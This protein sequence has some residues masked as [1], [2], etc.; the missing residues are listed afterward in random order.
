MSQPGISDIGAIQEGQ[1]VA[2]N[3]LELMTVGKILINLTEEIAMEPAKD[4]LS[5]ST[6]CPK[7]YHKLTGIICDVCKERM[8][9]FLLLLLTFPFIWV[10]KAS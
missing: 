2:R 6:S 3:Q 8:Y 10:G 1:Q 7:R 9:N 4:R 5:T